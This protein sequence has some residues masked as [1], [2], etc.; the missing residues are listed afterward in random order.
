MA[1]SLTR[2]SCSSHCD[3]HSRAMIPLGAENTVPAV[4]LTEQMDLRLDKTGNA[5]VGE[6][7][8]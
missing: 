4:L 7:P 5:L 3:S 2:A 6:S 1:N 8:M